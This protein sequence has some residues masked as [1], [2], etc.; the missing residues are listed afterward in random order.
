MMCVLTA[1]VP[2]LSGT[3]DQFHGREFFRRPGSGGQ[4]WF[5]DDSSALHLWCTYFC[6]HYIVIYNEIFIQFTIMQNHIS[7]H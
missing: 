6:Y 4:R 1:V 5:Q 3:R 7:R 2:N